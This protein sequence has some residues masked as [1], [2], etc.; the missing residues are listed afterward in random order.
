M[1]D[2][3]QRLNQAVKR[4]NALAEKRS[5]LEGRKE[6]AE[7]QLKKLRSQ[8]QEKG[9]DPDKASEVVEK[10]RVKLEQAVSAVEKKLKQAEDELTPFEDRIS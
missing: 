1:E 3:K 10:Y 2:L 5:N 9:I 4:R 6:E 7:A 8:C